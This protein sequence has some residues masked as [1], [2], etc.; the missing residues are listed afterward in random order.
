MNTFQKEITYWDYLNLNALLNSQDNLK[1]D[2]KDEKIF[3]TY[4]QICELY[5]LLIIHEIESI[6]ND[7]MIKK[8]FH[9]DNSLA[10]FDNWI[11]RLDKINNYLAL[12]IQSFS[13]LSP[14]GLNTEEFYKFRFA[15]Q[16]ASGFQTAQF[17]KMEIMLTDLNNLIIN[18]TDEIQRY[19]IEDKFEK[20]YWKAGAIDIDTGEKS[21]TLLAFE[22]KYNLE[23]L[24]LIKVQNTKNL[25]TLFKNFNNPFDDAS[26]KES[27]DWNKHKD[28]VQLKLMRV[29]NLMCDWKYKHYETVIEHFKQFGK[30]DAM[31]IGH[32]VRLD[33]DIKASGGTNTHEFLTQSLKEIRYFKK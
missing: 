33:G 10:V 7:D 23:F 31:N 29:D 18:P 28:L 8:Q 9:L 25:N 22:E 14:K 24:E 5:F 6:Q 3:L 11:N 15:L 20:I 17:R 13:I 4:H 27:K 12:L 32:S 19:P 1:T 30:I 21:K 26:S 16:P 2:F